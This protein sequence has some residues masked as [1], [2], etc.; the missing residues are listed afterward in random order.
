MAMVVAAQQ[1][2]TDCT[3]FFTVCI[4]QHLV[5]QKTTTTTKWSKKLFH[6]DYLLERKQRSVY[7][8]FC[9]FLS[10]RWSVETV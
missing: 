5:L 8:L 2:L 7:I 1:P 6:F 4:I 9:T 10:K 3:A